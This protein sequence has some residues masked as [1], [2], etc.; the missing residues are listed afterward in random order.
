MAW[1]TYHIQKLGVPGLDDLVA[2]GTTDLEDCSSLAFSQ[3]LNN[4]VLFAGV[5]VNEDCWKLSLSNRRKKYKV[6][7]RRVVSN[8]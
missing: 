5:V 8:P 4:S 6:Q 1:S 7:K 2:Q 3:L